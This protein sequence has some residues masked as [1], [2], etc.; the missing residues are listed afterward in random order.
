MVALRG[1]SGGERQGG[2]TEPRLGRI[3]ANRALRRPLRKS[4]EYQI[5]GSRLPTIWYFLAFT[6]RGR[7]PIFP[8]KQC[9]V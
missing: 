9:R 4:A 6:R 1:E 2:R 3:H 7:W 8:L 5:N